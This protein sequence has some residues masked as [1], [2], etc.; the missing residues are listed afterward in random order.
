[1]CLE[2]AVTML[3]YPCS[4]YPPPGMVSGGTRDDY[5]QLK[6][7]SGGFFKSIMVHVS[8][9]IFAELLSQ[10]EEDITFSE[11]GKASRE[12]LKQ[13]LREVITLSANRIAE[14]ENN[15]KGNLFMSLLMAQ[16]DA[17]EEGIDPGASVLDTATKSA[18]RC[19]DLLVARYSNMNDSIPP[20]DNDNGA[21]DTVGFWGG[22]DFGMNFTMQDWTLDPESNQETWFK[23]GFEDG[24]WW[25]C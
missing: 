21:N 18:D 8:M 17:M 4:D 1:M 7:I 15:I 24:A 22:Q 2:T 16:I 11:Q 3:K 13:C 14:V 23:S 20:V 12:H 9:V 10:I 25:H 19:Y 6:T 5:A